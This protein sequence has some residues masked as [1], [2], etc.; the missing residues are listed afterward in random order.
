MDVSG[1]VWLSG[2]SLILAFNQVV[3][4]LTSGGFQP[5]FMASLRSFLALAVL[6]IWMWS[7]NIAIFP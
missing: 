5:V 6:G 1:A 3:I 4:K 2:F 7:Q